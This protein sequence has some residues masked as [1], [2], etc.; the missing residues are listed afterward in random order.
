MNT[1]NTIAPLLAFSLLAA[2]QSADADGATCANIDDDTARLACYDAVF[3][4]SSESGEESEADEDII[5]AR[6]LGTFNGWSGNTEFKLDNGQVWKQLKNN[7]RP[8]RPR[9]PM[10]SPNVTIEKGLM[11]SYKLQV[12]GVK[13]T[14][15][16]KRIK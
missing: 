11:S 5:R 13:R 1:R 8:W 4:P 16:V 9:E 3:R 2:A 7:A 6:L 10:E 12:E 14:V 15:M